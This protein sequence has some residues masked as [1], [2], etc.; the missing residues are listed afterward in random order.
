M[1]CTLFAAEPRVALVPRDYQVK[2]HDECLRLWD[3]G[4][5]G[6]LT[7]IFTGG[8]KTPV[9]CMKMR[10]WLS[11]GA[12]YHCMVV[13]YERDLVWQFAQEISDFL[14]ID[15]GIEMADESIPEGD[16]PRIVVACRASLLPVKLITADQARDLAEH[17]I[18]GVDWLPRRYGER[19][20][21]ALGNGADE[22]EVRAQ[23]ESLRGRFAPHA[24]WSRLHKFDWRK[25]W[26]MFFD[27]AHR[28]AH[29]LKSVGHIADWFDRNPLSRRSGLTATPKRGDGISIGHKMFPGVAI[30]YPLFHVEK[31][32]AVKQGWAVPYVQKYIEVEGVDFKN[33]RQVAGD[34]DKAELELV[35]GEE[36]TL[37]KLVQPLLDLVGDR[38][39]LVFNPGVEMARNVAAFINARVEAACPACGARRWYPR[40]LVGDGARCAC[41][42]LLAEGHVTKAGEQ[43]R[44]TNGSTPPLDRKKTYRD[45]EAG[46]FQ[47]LSVCGLCREGY[48]SPDVSCVAVFRP[49][50]RKAS[51]LAEQMKGRG[52]RPC[53]SI[54]PVLNELLTPEERVEAIA[55]SGKPDRLIVD[56]V[57]ITGL[58][59]CASTLQIYADGLDDEVTALAEEILEQSA[60]DSTADVEGAIQK[61]QERI[62]A[63]REAE[64][65]RRRE[66]AER[67]AKAQAEV[68]YTEHQ[69]G[70]GSNV[71]PDR[72]T[73][74]QYKLIRLLGMDIK[75]P[76]TRRQAGRI[77]NQLKQRLPAEEVARVNRVADWELSG[78][79]DSQLWRL[80][81]LGVPEGLCRG[82]WEASQ[83]IGASKDPAEYERRK[84]A[85]IHG[86]ADNGSLTGIGKDVLLAR[87]VLPA[88]VYQRLLEAG[89]AKRAALLG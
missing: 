13:S 7:R 37:A 34:F 28:H 3:G 36:A 57:G 40:K 12:D 23:V 54:V 80:G 84:M 29:S 52:C 69:V 71:D 56:L 68:R 24:P 82:G 21:T 31:P 20:L 32:C 35:L 70:L 53:R 43:A 14:G 58:A 27:E 11:R 17:G 79:T 88:D 59:D 65:R 10:T 51:S 42:G 46:R 62:A 6:V 38:R 66:Q 15:P 75:A 30:D 33:I 49:V 83:V 5:R 19:A 85:E 78:P 60:R 2:D 77:I 1:T 81:R 63:E 4:E 73:A 61:A 44:S 8:G 87:R 86:A 45:Y 67:R 50:S 22:G 72:A 18:V 26:L 64:E 48:N 47:F 74:G 89:R 55:R 41:G 16:T 39:T 76:I 9:S 25:N